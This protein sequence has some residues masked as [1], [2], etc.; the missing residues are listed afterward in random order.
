MAAY[1]EEL[2]VSAEV[3]DD[4]ILALDEACTNVLKHAFPNA[5]AG[6]YILKADL[7]PEEVTVEV[8]DEG[9]GFDAMHSK[10]GDVLAVAGRGLEIMRRLMT[11]VEVE[12]PTAMGGT[13]LR[14]R[15][16]LPP[17]PPTLPPLPST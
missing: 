6:S 7:R 13:R 10:P 4:V 17:S 1:L 5:N 11:T 12:S 14:M 8:L 3:V 16:L 15:K 2:G 9:I